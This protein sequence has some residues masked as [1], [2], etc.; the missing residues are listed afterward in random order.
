MEQDDFHQQL[1]DQ[2]I[3]H[4]GLKL[5]PYLCPAGKLTIGV[6]RNLSDNGISEA[7]ARVLLA[8]D[9]AVSEAE[10]CQYPFW[11]DL[12]A[13][14]K[15]ALIDMHFNLGLGRFKKF[16]RMLAAIQAGDYELAAREMLDSKWARQVGKRAVT[17]ADMMV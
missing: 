16:K 17:L 8:N 13:A 2:L 10:L 12:S 4:E 1:C 3:R 6:G 14:R 9:I 15:M 7:E 11:R 5:H